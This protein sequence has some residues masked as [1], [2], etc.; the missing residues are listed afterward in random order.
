MTLSAIRMA[1]WEELTSQEPYSC[2]ARRRQE[3]VVTQQNDLHLKIPFF[4]DLEV[5]VDLKKHLSCSP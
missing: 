2:T 5:I 4:K 3:Q 1:G